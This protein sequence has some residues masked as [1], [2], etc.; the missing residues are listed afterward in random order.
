[1]KHSVFQLNFAVSAVAAVTLFVIG[2][3]APAKAADPQ[4]A[5]A[6][7]IAS[8]PSPKVAV[9]DGGDLISVEAHDATV[10][11]VIEVMGKRLKLSFANTE[12]ID[13]TRIVN[14]TR[15]GSIQHILSW[16]VP[17]GGFVVYYQEEKTQPSDKPGR[18]ERI[19]FLDGGPANAGIPSGSTRE[20][21]KSG[22][23]DAQK[24]RAAA[25]RGGAATVT[26]G[27]RPAG[28]GGAGDTGGGGD[29]T[30]KPD[31]ADTGGIHQLLTVPEQLRASTVDAQR[32]IDRQQNSP[33][34]QGPSPA[35]LNG[36]NNV[37]ASSL[38]QQMQ[39]S[40]ALAT[41]Q[42]QALRQALSAACSGGNGAPC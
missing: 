12:R 34:G 31:V 20:S 5:V 39:R 41:A 18:P 26:P 14:G 10:A 28:P 15:I 17:L 11:E 4:R 1:M 19:G 42:L 32:E 3:Q 21:S 37:A 7:P 27:G 16:L 22:T 33:T 23:T 8:D 35:F 29:T 40:Q 6:P 36:P 25:A 9:L 2:G 38:E 13:T 30:G 24:A